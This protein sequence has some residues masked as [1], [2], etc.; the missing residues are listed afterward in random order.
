MALISKARGLISNFFPQKER[1][2]VPWGLVRVAACE[3][4][5]FDTCHFRECAIIDQ[6]CHFFVEFNWVSQCEQ[7]DCT[8]SC[9]YCK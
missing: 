5:R 7:H 6:D 1:G 9:L 4:Y 3:F 2:K 8:T